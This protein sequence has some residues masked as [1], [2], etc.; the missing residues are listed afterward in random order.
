MR[1]RGGH[2]AAGRR[3]PRRGRPL[4]AASLRA[5]CRCSSS[6]TSWLDIGR[7]SPNR[8]LA[9]LAQQHGPLMS[10][11]LGVV[12]AVVVSS[13]DAAHEID[14]K[15]NVAPP[16]RGG[17]G[18]LANSIIAGPPHVREEKA[19][20][21]V[22]HVAAK[23]AAGEPVTVQDPV[24]T[25]AM[26]MLSGAL[27]SVDLDSGPEYLQGLR[28]RMAPLIANARRILDELSA[29]S[30]RPA[31]AVLSSGKAWMLVRFSAAPRHGQLDGGRAP[32]SRLSSAIRGSGRLVRRDSGERTVWSGHL[33]FKPCNFAD[34]ESQNQTGQ[35]PGNMSDAVRRETSAGHASVWHGERREPQCEALPNLPTSRATTRGGAWSSARA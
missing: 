19:A 28:R 12:R 8:S 6:A 27:F 29:R 30:R 25:A 16:W 24:F 23:A 21:L 2:E 18:H 10:V 35:P 14:Q 33:A 7:G 9:R 3:R 1:R 34:S 22:R 20:E 26:N 15:R 5:P 17:N 13:S 32:W 31:A 11:R 4:A